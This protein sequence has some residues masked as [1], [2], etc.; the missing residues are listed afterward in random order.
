MPIPSV[1]KKKRK[2]EWNQKNIMAWYKLAVS[3]TVR[4]IFTGH[5]QPAF[6]ENLPGKH[7]E[8]NL[9]ALNINT[10][11]IIFTEGVH[12]TRPYYNLH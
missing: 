4:R 7:P 9:T 11:L 3:Q 6:S 10:T 2:N 1:N 12:L 8:T 5:Q